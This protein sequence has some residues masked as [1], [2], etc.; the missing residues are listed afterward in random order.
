MRLLFSV[1][2][3]LTGFLVLAPCAHAERRVALVIGNGAYVSVANLPN[4]PRDATAIGD[5]F[6]TAG[7]DDVTV[8]TDLGIAQMRAVLR[9]FVRKAADADIAAVFHAGHGIEVG[10]HNYIIPVDAKLELETDVEDEA[11]DLDRVLQQLEPVKRL[12]LVILDAC[13]EDPFA[14]R[15]R[16]LGQSRD[17]GRGLSPPTRQG[18]DTL[19]AFAA[20]AGAMA[21]D[22]VGAHSP[23]TSALLNNLTRP[24]LDVRLALGKVRDEVLKDTSGR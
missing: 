1:L 20:A 9:E 10:G 8:R 4:P 6:K 2:V 16:S 11:I 7:F 21:A 5:L 23:F 17:I 14:P 12:K 18:A 3:F 19:V 13:R 24:G 15:M 22:G